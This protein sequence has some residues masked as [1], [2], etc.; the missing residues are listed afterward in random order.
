MSEE[1]ELKLLKK[2]EELEREIK[3]LK[4]E[5]ISL[6]PT[7]QFSKIRDVDLENLFDIYQKIDRKRFNDWFENNINIT[8]KDELYLSD[9]LEQEGDYISFYSEEDLKMR[10]L[11]LLFRKVDFKTEKFRD[12]YNEK[13]VY[14]T[15]KFILSGEVDF[16]VSTGLRIA[17][18]PYFF[19]QEFKRSEEYSNPRPQLLAELVSA[20]ELNNFTSIRGAYITGAIWNFVILEKLQKDKYQYF[21]STNFDSTKLEDLKQIYKN[22]FFVKEE[23]IKMIK[24]EL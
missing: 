16:V 14:K 18:K 22:L 4:G 15:E 9:L 6:V 12:F 3:S 8:T 11:S 19:I 24:E 1:I 5:E 20:I 17:K 10:F 13:L 23:I 7:Y 2:I 21:V